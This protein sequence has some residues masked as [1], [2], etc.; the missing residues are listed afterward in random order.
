MSSLI[1]KRLKEGLLTF[2]KY[3]N[4]M[5]KLNDINSFYEALEILDLN[6]I[7]SAKMLSEINKN[8]DESCMYILKSR[9]R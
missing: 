5:N 1:Y 8:Y 4:N 6:Y 7:K 9:N 3:I 2:D